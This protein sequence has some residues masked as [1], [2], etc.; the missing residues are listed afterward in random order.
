MS[1]IKVDQLSDADIAK[2]KA[3]LNSSGFSLEQTEQ[4]AVAKGMSASEFAKLKAR[5]AAMD[6]TGDKSATGKLKSPESKSDVRENN[7]SDSLSVPHYDRQKPKSLIDSLIF[8]SEL[9]TSVAPSFEPNM[10]LATPVNYILGP[11]DVLSVSVYG[12][13]VYEGELSVSADGFISI[14]NVGQVKLTGLPIEAATQKLKTAMSAVYSSLRSGGSK[15]SVTLS[16]IRSI[17]VNVVGSYFPGT[18]TVSSLSTVFNVLYLAGGPREVGSFREIELIRAGEPTRKIDLYKFL[19]NG[20]QSDNI[21]LKDNDVIRIPAY[22][23]R[24]EL[25]GQ[26]KRPGI[27]EVLPGESFSD[28]LA[29]ASG[30]TDTAYMASVKIFQRSDRERKVHDLIATD[31][32]K[33]KPQAGEIFAISKILNRFQNRVRITGAVFRPDVYE[34]TPG[35]TAVDLIRKADG[36]REDA[37]TGR[38]QVLRLEED[39]TRSIVPFDIR[40]ALAGDA[41]NNPVLQREDEVLISAISDLR[42][43]FKVSIQGEIRLP[44]QYDYVNGLTLKDIV[45]Q[46]GGFTDAAFKN[47]EIARLIRR[48][49][50]AL[51]D[52][53]ASAVINIDVAGDLSST[54]ANM[55]LQP[56]D[57]IT[58]RRKAGYILPE[59][60]K[61]TGQVQYPGPYALSRSDERVSDILLRSGGF[62]PDAYPAGAYIKRYLTDIEKQ[63]SLEAL[64]KAEKQMKDSIGANKTLQDEINKQYVQIPLELDKIMLLPGSLED[65]TLKANDELYVP[66]YNAGVKISGSILQSTQIPYDKSNS[67]R[68]YIYAA[69]GYSADAWRKGTYIVYANGKAAS[70]K[71]FLFFKS[72][73]NVQPGSEIVVPKRMDRKVLSTGEVIGISSALASLAGVVIA[74]LNL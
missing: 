66:K 4:M 52:K 11:G 53:R 35:L 57:V 41:A 45:L 17:K 61:V 48:D 13:Q 56:F 60:V 12:V 29:F 16:K 37:Y 21:G 46:A 72:Y 59:T 51:T 68:D 27:F 58:I 54:T 42:D 10:N 26:V 63:Q 23:T 74:I 44:G 25:Q 55:P 30:F 49:S 22:K 34:L 50:L 5:L 24:V 38:A 14:P 8:G 15:L 31:F 18:F 20:D 64:K 67:F 43:S 39:L 47:I 71:R 2:L 70:I 73:P 7:S 40:K 33:Y 36:L 65:I 3:Q 9:Y 69:G 6:N 32:E 62:A 19:V 1:Q 28:I